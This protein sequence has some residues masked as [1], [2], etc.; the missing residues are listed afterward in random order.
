MSFLKYF[1]EYGDRYECNIQ[2]EDRKCGVI[3]KKKIKLASNNQLL[4]TA[5]G[6]N[7]C[8]LNARDVEFCLMVGNSDRSGLVLAQG[9]RSLGCINILLFS[10]EN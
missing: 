9:Y 2:D 1:D 6:S 10:G 8:V 7:R 3:I 4:N 5:R